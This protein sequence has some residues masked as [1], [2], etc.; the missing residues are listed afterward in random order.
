VSRRRKPLPGTAFGTT[1]EGGYELCARCGEVLGNGDRV[2]AVRRSN[3]WV[4]YFHDNICLTGAKLNGLELVDK[5]H[6]AR[7]AHGLPITGPLNNGGCSR[8]TDKQ[9]EYLCDLEMDAVT[10]RDYDFLPMAPAVY[11]EMENRPCGGGRHISAGMLN[12]AARYLTRKW[13]TATTEEEQEE[14]P[15]PRLKPSPTTLRVAEIVGES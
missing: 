4:I 3:D 6:A 11:A 10:V 13:R 5:I 1:I 9:I 7:R 2:C 8:L 15:K 12:Q 14:L